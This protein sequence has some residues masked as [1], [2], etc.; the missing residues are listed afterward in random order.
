MMQRKSTTMDKSE[1]LGPV[2]SVYSSTGIGHPYYF[3][4]KENMV[5]LLDLRLGPKNNNR[6][7][8]RLHWSVDNENI[9]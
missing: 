6:I 5:P 8:A 9:I 3:H 2:R 1:R 4:S 7:L